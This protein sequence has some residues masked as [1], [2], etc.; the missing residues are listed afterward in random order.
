MKDNTVNR[1]HPRPLPGFEAGYYP[2]E[3]LYW[4][5]A[6]HN[7]AAGLAGKDNDVRDT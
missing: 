7:S 5:D 6:E 3:W 2:A 4:D 1:L